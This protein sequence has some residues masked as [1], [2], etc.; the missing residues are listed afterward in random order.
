MIHSSSKRTLRSV[1]LV[2]LLLL[3]VNSYVAYRLYDGSNEIRALVISAGEVDKKEL[4]AGSIRTIQNMA[5]EELSVF[6]KFTL[7]DN[8]LVAVIEDIEGVGQ[9]LGL[10]IDIKAVDKEGEGSKN[11]QK[12]RITLSSRGAWPASTLFFRALENLP[13][14][15]TFES[16]SLDKRLNLWEGEFA[17]ILSTFN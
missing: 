1:S 4:L 10:E 11:M 3:L 9:N 5:A 8:E 12:I 17:L 6:E 15:V 14:L 2:A 7:T 13:Y 16:V